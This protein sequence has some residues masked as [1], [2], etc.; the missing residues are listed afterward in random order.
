MKTSDSAESRYRGS[1]LSVLRVMEGS[2]R[3][4]PK[5]KGPFPEPES[6]ERLSCGPNPERPGLVVM[7]TFMEP[8]PVT[9]FAANF[10]PIP[11]M[12]PP[13]FGRFI[14]GGET[15]KLLSCWLVV[16]FCAFLWLMGNTITFHDIGFG[17]L[18]KMH[19]TTIYNYR[20][21]WSGNEIEKHFFSMLIILKDETRQYSFF[22]IIDLDSNF[23]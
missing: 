15:A 7:G 17:V 2:D 4:Q 22:V 20:C 16:S 9:G 19:S 1:P 18:N 23:S 6:Y 13:L 8:V 5:P 10:S 12:A 21:Q 3:L 14:A 11:R